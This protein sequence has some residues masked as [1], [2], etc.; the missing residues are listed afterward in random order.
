MEEEG[1]EGD[2]ATEGGAGG[3]RRL[4]HGWT[5]AHERDADAKARKKEK[6]PPTKRVATVA[7]A[8]D[9][10]YNFQHNRGIKKAQKAEQKKARKRAAASSMFLG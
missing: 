9:D 10:K 3:A 4:L 1:R 5:Q 8:D 2:E 6:R 7:L